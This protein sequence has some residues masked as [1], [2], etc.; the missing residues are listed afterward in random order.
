MAELSQKGMEVGTAGRQG[1]WTVE[2]E[3]LFDGE[4]KATSFPR[5]SSTALSRRP[6]DSIS[7]EVAPSWENRGTSRRMCIVFRE[8][9]RG[10]P[11]K[12]KRRNLSQKL[13]SEGGGF[14]LPGRWGLC[15]VAQKGKA[16]PSSPA[17]ETCRVVTGGK[18]G[19]GQFGGGISTA[20]AFH[21]LLSV[22]GG[23]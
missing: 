10:Q 11:A 16:P 1:L 17:W 6:L 8:I 13:K 22:V 14:I 12:W 19:E 20:C 15:P 2:I 23:A 18:E 3:S 21:P 4:S 9:V 7:E 5:E